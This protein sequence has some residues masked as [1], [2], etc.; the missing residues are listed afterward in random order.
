MGSEGSELHAGKSQPA[1]NLSL[2]HALCDFSLGR[3]CIWSFVLQ[4]FC[5]CLFDFCFEGVG[6]YRAAD[7]F[8]FIY[9]NI[10]LNKAK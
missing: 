9:F 6:G 7:Q 8:V 3:T 4:S 10:L 5:F 2:V 1:P